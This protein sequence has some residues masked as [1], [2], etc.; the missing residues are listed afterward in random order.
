[1]D[2]VPTNETEEEFH[3]SVLQILE[4]RKDIIDEYREMISL[5]AGRTHVNA[6]DSTAKVDSIIE[7]ARQATILVAAEANLKRRRRR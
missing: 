2:L 3:G 7:E 1:M 4:L 6:D 5:W